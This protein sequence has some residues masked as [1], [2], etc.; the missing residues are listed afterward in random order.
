MN[1][2]I[3][4]VFFII[5][6]LLT[7]IISVSLATQFMQISKTLLFFLLFLCGF[8]GMPYAYIVAKE[9]YNKYGYVRSF[10]LR[11]IIGYSFALLVGAV[12]LLMEL[13]NG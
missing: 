10:T 6:L 2:K 4:R 5:S 1:K 9:Y 3:A 11:G 7:V 12:M 13:F 8:F